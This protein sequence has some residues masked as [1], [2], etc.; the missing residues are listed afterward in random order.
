MTLVVY[1]IVER[2][3]SRLIGTFIMKNVCNRCHYATC[4]IERHRIENVM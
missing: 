3:I 2:P 4:N 1:K